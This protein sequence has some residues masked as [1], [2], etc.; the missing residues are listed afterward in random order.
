M[1]DGIPQIGLGTWLMTPEEAEASVTQALELG[2]THIDTAQ[3]YGDEGGVGRALTAAGEAGRSTFVTTKIEARWKTAPEAA[4]SID[5][6]LE[7]LQRDYID[8]ILIHSPQPWDHRGDEYRYGPENATVFE[9]MMAAKEAGKLR[10]IGVSNFNID[11]LTTIYDH[12]G[13]WPEANQILAHPGNM[14][15]QLIAFCQDKSITVE[16]YSPVGHGEILRNPTLTD[17]AARYDSTVTAVCL[18]YL[19]GKGLVILPKTTNPEHM[20]DNLAISR[21]PLPLSDGD[22]TTLDQLTDIDYGESQ[23]KYWIFKR[24]DYYA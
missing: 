6:S 18:S 2:Y 23:E 11:D 8:L 14:S 5:R 20:R 3:G 4:A 9:A 19:L 15:H 22:I 1:I 13:Q 12:T 16:A 7:L 10:H 24:P 21:E 17:M